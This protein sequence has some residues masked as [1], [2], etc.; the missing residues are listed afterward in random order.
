[1]STLT[2]QVNGIEAARHVIGGQIEEAKRSLTAFATALEGLKAESGYPLQSL[3]GLLNLASEAAQKADDND[4]FDLV[5][6]QEQMQKMGTAFE[7]VKKN[8]EKLL[9]IKKLHGNMPAYIQS[10]RS[11]IDR[12]VQAEG[13]MM[14]DF[15]PYASFDSFEKTLKDALR[16]LELGEALIAEQQ[17]LSIQADYK[18]GIEQCKE[19]AAMRDRTNATLSSIAQNVNTLRSKYSAAEAVY[20]RLT[21]SFDARHY[22]DYPGALSQMT[23]VTNTS[24]NAAGRIRELNSSSVQQYKIAEKEADSL[25]TNVRASLEH[26]EELIG[27]FDT[28]SRKKAELVR[29]ISDQQTELSQAKSK[30]IQNSIIHADD[31]GSLYLR[32]ERA[33]DAANRQSSSRVCNLDEM[34]RYVSEAKNDVTAFERAVDERVA[35]KRRAEEQLRSLQRAGHG[36]YDRYRHKGSMSRYS[37]SYDSSMGDAQRMIAMGMFAQALIE[38]DRAKSYERDMERE[39]DRI[40]SEEARENSSSSSSSSGSSSGGSDWGSST[41]TDSTS[42]GSDSGGSSW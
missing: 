22:A 11:E 15:K 21:E 29:H 8:A 19:A 20:S 36:K 14:A 2:S 12:I 40:A 5:E 24:Q 34:A 31:L 27:R 9:S 32:A 26:A 1:M 18:E 33:L 7:K 41:T 30:Q 13:L 10:A 4:E 3:V 17:L 35:Q 6:A 16:D 23:D 28:L 38:I 25:D 39:Y 37:S 42:S